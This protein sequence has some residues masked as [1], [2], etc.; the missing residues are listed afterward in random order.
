MTERLYTSPITCR[1]DGQA[2]QVT[3]E[4]VAAGR[5]AGSYGALCG[6]VVVPAPMIAPVGRSCPECTAVLALQQ[7]D[8]AT[9]SGRR[10]RHRKR[11]RLW[12]MLHPRGHPVAGA[13]ASRPT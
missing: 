6:H 12:R 13:A 10:P 11:G 7:P 3:D 5:G 9:A 4:G 8:P 2:H 1:L